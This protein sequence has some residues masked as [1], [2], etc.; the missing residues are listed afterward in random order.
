[1]IV[2][3]YHPI[4][5]NPFCIFWV[6]LYSQGAQSKQLRQHCQT[7]QSLSVLQRQRWIPGSTSLGCIS[8]LQP[9]NMK[10]IQDL[11]LEETK[12]KDI[13]KPIE[14]DSSGEITCCARRRMTCI[15]NCELWSSSETNLWICLKNMLCSWDPLRLAPT[16]LLQSPRSAIWY[17]GR[18]LEDAS[19]LDV[20]CIVWMVKV[21]QL[22]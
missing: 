14:M 20:P 10:K 6:L 19:I 17:L 8:T 11:T 9:A 22:S 21:L 15:L 7:K 2:D 18:I 5:V 13:E 4:P 3:Q 1:M 12:C 16:L